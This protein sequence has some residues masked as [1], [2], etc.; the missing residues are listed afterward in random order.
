MKEKNTFDD[1]MA[2][3]KNFVE[4]QKGVWDHT[5]WEN[6]LKD[7]QKKGLALTEETSQAI[8]GLLESLKKIYSMHPEESQKFRDI[9]SHAKA[10]VEKYKGLWDHE[11]WDS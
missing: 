9:T 8:G 7:M 11:K 1:L 6:F 4:K 5:H 10:F 3:A 2:S